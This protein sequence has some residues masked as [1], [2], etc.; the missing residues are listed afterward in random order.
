MLHIPNKKTFKSTSPLEH[1]HFALSL[2][3]FLQK[4]RYGANAHSKSAISGA[5]KTKASPC[6]VILP[7]VYLYVPSHCMHR[8]NSL[9]FLLDI[10]SRSAPVSFYHHT[11]N[12]V[13]IDQIGNVGV[14]LLN[15]VIPLCIDSICSLYYIISIL[16]CPVCIVVSCLVCIVAILCVFVVLCV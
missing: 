6:T 5:S 4:I 1:I 16:R 12:T 13:N 11:R 2:T 8:P 9:I 14:T 3:Q 7:N 15:K 10:P